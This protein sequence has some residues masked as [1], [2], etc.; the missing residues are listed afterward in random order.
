MDINTCYKIGFVQKTHGLKGE[1][2]AM[3]D[4]DSADDLEPNSTVFLEIDDRLIPY[5]IESLSVTGSKAFVKFEDVDT[6]DQAATLVRSS[7][8]LEKSKRAKKGRGE[9]YDD[10]IVGF[11]VTDETAGDL[12]TVTGIV[13]AGANKLIS[14][15]RE[16][17][18]IL[19]PVNAP[20]IQGINKSKRTI[21]V[22][23]PD[24]YLD[25]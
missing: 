3:L 5:F 1:V 7:L 17:T 13:Q 9:F 6:I 23:L 24:G 19:I 10:E 25:I 12:G 8:F 11:T 2:T 14:I 4:A 16:G 22:I 21:R 18:E 20:F 15:D